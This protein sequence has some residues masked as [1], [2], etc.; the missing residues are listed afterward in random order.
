M[1]QGQPGSVRNMS[2]RLRSRRGQNGERDRL[3]RLLLK[4]TT[5]DNVPDVLEQAAIPMLRTSL[6]I[7][8]IWFGA[9]KMLGAS[10]V[11]DLVAKTMAPVPAKVSVPAVGLWETTVGVGF[12]TRRALKLILPMFFL[13]IM[14]VFG[15]VLRRP[16]ELVQRGNPLLLTRDGEFMLKNLVLLSAGLVIAT[17]AGE[18]HEDVQG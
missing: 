16:Q 17:R 5:A 9:L 1:K 4:Q 18:P 2:E 15:Y 13:Q 3:A 10:P 7:V 12:L 11:A 8:Y 14:G 6:A